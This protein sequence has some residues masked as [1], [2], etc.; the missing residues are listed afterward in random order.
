MFNLTLVSDLR[1]PWR[2]ESA[3]DP[4]D[5]MLVVK[6]RFCTSIAD[7]FRAIGP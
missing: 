6:S 4:E 7:N 2:I 1:S 5:I 3:I